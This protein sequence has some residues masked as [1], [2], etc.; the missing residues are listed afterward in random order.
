MNAASHSDATITFGAFT[1]AAELFRSLKTHGIVNP[2]DEVLRLVS[3]A[4]WFHGVAT[5]RMLPHWSVWGA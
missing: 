5:V 3:S 2:A 4:S 1:P